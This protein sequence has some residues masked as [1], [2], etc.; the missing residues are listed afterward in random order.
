MPEKE[1]HR[2]TRARPRSAFAVAFISR[3]SLWLGRDHLLCVDSSGYTETYKRFYFRD[4]Q[5]VTI[6]ATKRRTVF[7]GVLVVPVDVMPLLVHMPEVPVVVGWNGVDAPVN[8]YAELR[9]DVPFRR[10]VGL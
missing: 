4:I 1:Y 10:L 5:A 8:E 7:N 9:I 3:S 6:V 2:L